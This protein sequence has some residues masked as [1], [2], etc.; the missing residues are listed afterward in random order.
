[1]DHLNFCIECHDGQG[2][3]LD[4]THCTS[5]TCPSKVATKR[6]SILLTKTPSV[7]GVSVTP[8]FAA[9]SSSPPTTITL[10]SPRAN[11]FDYSHSRYSSRQ[12]SQSMSFDSI[13]SS[14]IH[15]T[16]AT[17]DSRVEGSGGRSALCSDENFSES[18]VEILDNSLLQP[19]IY[20]YV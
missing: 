13:S 11:P 5:L 6:N 20:G 15:S 1:M 12:K 7:G 4:G 10:P 19:G 17:L 2:R 9:V 18:D 14:P 8:V 3:K 16:R